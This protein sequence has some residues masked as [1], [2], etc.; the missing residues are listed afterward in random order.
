[1]ALVKKLT[2]VLVLFL[3]SVAN[4]AQERH[5]DLI[6]SSSS[7]TEKSLRDQGFEFIRRQNSGNVTFSYWWKAA[8]KTCLSVQ[9][10]YGKTTAVTGKPAGECGRDDSQAYIFDLVGQST[11]KA[12]STLLAQGFELTRRQNSGYTSMSYWWKGA[13]QTCLSLRGDNGKTTSINKSSP[14]DCGKGVSQSN[15]YGLVGKSTYT[16][17]S[18]LRSR[19][20]QV[21][22]R[23]NSGNTV[24]GYWWKK[25][26]NT[27][28]GLRSDYGKVTTSVQNAPSECA[29]DETQGIIY[30]I[31]GKSTWTGESYLVSKGFELSRKQNS[32]NVVYGYWWRETTRTC[33]RVRI[34]N[35]RIT[36]ADQRSARDCGKDSTTE[37][38]YKD[39]IGYKALT[40]YDTLRNRGYGDIKT[41]NKDGNHWIVWKHNKTQKCIKSKERN[42]IIKEVTE[43]NKCF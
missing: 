8:T 21:S 2:F 30:E 22:R 9:S 11:Y 31:V 20:F 6:G 1:M 37:G 34:E 29:K 32:G 28:I 23:Q 25:S 13:T 3:I 39:L 42:G 7:L 27:C 33:L 26:T 16:A 17:E 15:V 35:G 43:S 12:E 18:Y 38:Q 19:G 14:G 36:A 40:A 5:F 24:Y 4:Y 41:Y 10:E